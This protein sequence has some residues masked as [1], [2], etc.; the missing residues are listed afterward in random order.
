MNGCI[1]EGQFLGAFEHV[2]HHFCSQRCPCSVLDE[3]Y[4]TILEVSLCQM[5]DVLF[6]EWEDVCI[7]CSG[8]KYQFA[9]AECIFHCLC[10]IVAGKV[11]YSN[12]RAS[13][14]DEF[15]L[16]KL[17]RFFGMSVYRSISDHNAFALNC[18]RRPDIIK[19]DVISQVFFQDWSMQRTDRLNVQ[20]GCFFQQVLYLCTVFSNDTDVVTACLTCPVFFYIESTEFSETICGKQN[21][22]ICIISNDYFWPMYH[23]S[24]YKCQCMLSKCQCIAFFNYHLSVSKICAEELLHHH[25]CFLR[26]NNLGIFECLHKVS[27]IRGVVRLHMLN[28]QVIR[29]AGTEN[30]LNVVQPLMCKA[31]IYRIHNC[32]LI[33]HDHIRIVCHT[34]LYYILSLKQVH[35]MIVHTYILNVFRNL[36]FISSFLLS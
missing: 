2:L 27:N 22:V 13:F 24:S 23:R 14:L 21:L 3:S 18:V 4:G 9:V 36:H 6:H 11:K 29:T 31:G 32:N 33:I 19:I 5:M 17:N 10:H 34:I 12:F 26:G 30:R 7:V 15:L 8:G 20:S 25:K 28:N 16:Q 35:I 1:C